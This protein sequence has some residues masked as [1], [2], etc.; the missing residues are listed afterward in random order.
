MRIVIASAALALFL[1]AA[2]GY[3]MLDRGLLRFNYPGRDA[4]PV[5]GVDV[6]HHQGDIDWDRL[7]NEGIQFAYIKASE[8]G[9]LQDE[10]FPYNWAGASRAAVIPG[11]YHYYSLCTPPA[12][13][14]QNFLTAAP[15][16]TTVSLPPAVDLE[17]AGNC[18]HRPSPAQIQNDL[19]MFLDT[20]E[21][22]WGRPVVLYVTLEFYP[23]L[24]HR[25]PGN[26][27]WVRDVYKRP[28]AHEFGRWRFWQYANRG[29]LKG[30]GNPVD[31]DVFAGSRRDF[32]AFIKPV[33]VI[34]AAPGAR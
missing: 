12:R 9:T 19:R 8:G 31:L 32:D 11:A 13:Q 26:P 4:F 21:A 7:G 33:H 15:P 27:I 34:P 17:F 1:A 30:V 6:S 29:L 20:V 24:G 25:F 23:S 3:L 14:A 5:R 22:A 28:D 16:S 2:F 10:R 18:A